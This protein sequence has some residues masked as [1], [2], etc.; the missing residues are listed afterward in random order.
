MVLLIV[1]V[2]IFAPLIAP[3]PGDAGTATHPFAVLKRRRRRTG[4]APTRSAA[5]SFAG[6]SS[7][8]AYRRVIAI[9][10]LA[11]RLR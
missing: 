1:L 3:F 5:T 9:V 2:A 6:S 10:V 4:S 11:D 8:R 7:A